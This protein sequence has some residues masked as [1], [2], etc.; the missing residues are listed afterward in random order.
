MQQKTKFNLLMITV[1]VFLA[2]VS[3]SQ[4]TDLTMGEMQVDKENL[5]K[6]FGE[7]PYSPLSL[8]HI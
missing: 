6:Q 5:A 2:N 7:R 8:I 3:L 1:S 4:A